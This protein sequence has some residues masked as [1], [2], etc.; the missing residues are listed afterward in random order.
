VASIAELRR[1]MAR[2]EAAAQNLSEGETQFLLEQRAEMVLQTVNLYLATVADE[3]K[4]Y[5]GTLDKYIGDCV[6]AFWGAPIEDPDHALHCVQAAIAAQ[7]AMAALN[8]QR[9]AAAPP[10]S[11]P[12]P[13]LQLGT[14]INTG[15]VTVGLVGSSQHILNYTAFGREVNLASRLESASGRARILISE[16]T[17]ADLRRADPA[18]AAACRPLPPVT[19]KGFREPVPVFE[20]P[21]RLDGAPAAVAVGPEA[22][23]R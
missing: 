18:L 16:A 7:R 22:P 9:V 13:T 6:M 17:L 23:P 2:G 10:G 4:R 14:G 11:P 12:P 5:G 19:M 21:G 8:R 3:V 20:V 1:I 15:V